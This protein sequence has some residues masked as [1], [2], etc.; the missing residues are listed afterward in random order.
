MDDGS[1]DFQPSLF[2][3]PNWTGSETPTV[4]VF[5]SFDGRFKCLLVDD[6]Q[7]VDC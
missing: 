4:L 6:D 3:L 5:N 2:A 7:F 1:V